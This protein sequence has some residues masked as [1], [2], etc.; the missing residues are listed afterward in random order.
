MKLIELRKRMRQA[1]S[2]S[3]KLA[4]VRDDARNIR[5]IVGLIPPGYY[6]VEV[7]SK[8]YYQ[9]DPG[10]Q[11]IMVGGRQVYVHSREHSRSTGKY[12]IVVTTEAHEFESAP[13]YCLYIN[14]LEMERAFIN[15]T[16]LEYLITMEKRGWPEGYLIYIMSDR[17]IMADDHLLHAQARKG[18]DS[19]SLD[20][21]WL[22]GKFFVKLPWYDDAKKQPSNGVTRMSGKELMAYFRR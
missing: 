22:K 1:P 6:R 20:C 3:T 4:E 8:I 7:G 13:E 12:F 2:V 5:D 17:D 9:A 16:G 15:K 11:P 19:L 18:Y 14:P 21:Y 10:G